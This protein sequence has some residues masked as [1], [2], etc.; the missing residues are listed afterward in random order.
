MEIISIIISGLAL[1]VSVISWIQS[2]KAQS[3][4]N[5][6]NELDLKLKGFELAEKERQERELSRSCVEA[7]V[8]SIGKGKYKLKVWNSGNTAV[9][10]VTA[11]IEADG[12]IMMDREKMP[13]DQLEPQKDFDVSLIVAGQVDRKFHIITEWTDANGQKQSKDQMGDI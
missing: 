10:D 5:R 7:R 2:S 9:S 1:I 13:F 8:T 3:L 12:I 6:I 11:R 4:Q